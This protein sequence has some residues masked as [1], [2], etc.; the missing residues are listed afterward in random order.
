VRET[1]VSVFIAKNDD[2][3]RSMSSTRRRHALVYL[4]TMLGRDTV[5]L[6]AGFPAVSV[7]VN[8][9]VDASLARLRKIRRTLRSCRDNPGRGG[10]RFTSLH[11]EHVYGKL[12]VAHRP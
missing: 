3:R 7:F 6:A 8:D 12:A 1:R 9:V 4:E 11:L 2:G 10:H 5:S